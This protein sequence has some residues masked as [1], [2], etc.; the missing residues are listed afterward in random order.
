M[1]FLLIILTFLWYT[2]PVAAIILFVWKFTS[3]T[4]DKIFDGIINNHK[5]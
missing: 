4:T 3:K 5:N 2:A 1:T